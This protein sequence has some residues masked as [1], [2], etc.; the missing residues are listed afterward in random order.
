M[1]ISPVAMSTPPGEIAELGMF[2]ADVIGEAAEGCATAT[3]VA[4]ADAMSAQ[5]IERS[6]DGDGC[7]LAAPV[8]AQA[9]G[10]QELNPNSPCLG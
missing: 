2:A 8:A 5:R 3:C 7:M 10:R 1:M 4:R 6:P 9:F